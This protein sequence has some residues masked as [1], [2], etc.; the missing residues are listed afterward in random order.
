MNTLL[1]VAHP[2]Y[3]RRLARELN[4][5]QDGFYGPDGQRWQR[6]H[7]RSVPGE[8]GTKCT[9]HVERMDSQ[10]PNRRFSSAYGSEAVFTDAFGRRVV[11]SRHVEP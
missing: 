9:L 7:V 5:L 6:A 10:N 11:A 4:S 3:L 2:T 1:E 8:N